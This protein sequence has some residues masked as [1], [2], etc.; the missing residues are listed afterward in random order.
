MKQ[1]G[2][3]LP[4]RAGEIPMPQNTGFGLF[5]AA[6]SFLLGFGI[7]WHIWWLAV[8]GV[9]LCVALLMVRSFMYAGE[10]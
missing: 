5:V 3:K 8:V 2:Q 7:I 10:H 6:G 1:K 4:E 9:V